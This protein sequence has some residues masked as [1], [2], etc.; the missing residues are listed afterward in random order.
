MLEAIIII[1]LVATLTGVSVRIGFNVGERKAYDFVAKE[2]SLSLEQR[3][4]DNA[5]GTPIAAQLARE[6]RMQA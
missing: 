6:M 2:L 3:K 4:R 1:A 5:T